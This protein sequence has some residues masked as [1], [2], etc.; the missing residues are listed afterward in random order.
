[1]FEL[2]LFLV[3]TMNHVYAA[4]YSPP[5]QVY[6]HVEYS[7]YSAASGVYV[8]AYYTDNYGISRMVKTKTSD[9]PEELGYYFFNNSFSAAKQGT[10]IILKI[11]DFQKEIIPAKGTKSIL[12]NTIFLGTQNDLTTGVSQYGDFSSSNTQS[13]ISDEK[14]STIIA[15]TLS[16][17]SGNALGGVPI[18]ITWTD[19]SDQKKNL[20]RYTLTKEEASTQGGEEGSYFTFDDE[21]DAKPD[22]TIEIT[23][24][25]NSVTH[26]LISNPGG[27]LKADITQKN[28]NEILTPDK[29]S[30]P[31]TVMIQKNATT[32]KM[33]KYELATIMI[34]LL[35]CI[36][37]IYKDEIFGFFAKI[38]LKILDLKIIKMK[39]HNISEVVSA[40]ELLSISKERSLLD[41]INIIKNN[42]MEVLAVKDNNKIIG[43]IS[44]DDIIKNMDKQKES[45]DKI[46]VK[47]AM[48]S[49]F[50]MTSENKDYFEIMKMMISEKSGYAAIKKEKEIAGIITLMD[51]A[52]KLDEII[53]KKEFDQ[54]TILSVRYLVDDKG[55]IVAY[56]DDKLLDTLKKMDE[57]NIKLVLISKKE[58]EEYAGMITSKEI[59]IEAY[60]HF[61]NLKASK[62]SFMMNRNIPI[63]RPFN[64]IFEINK[65]MIEKNTHILPVFDDKKIL[66]VITQEK[67]LKEIETILKNMKII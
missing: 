15:G 14:T 19:Y 21:I 67:I 18:T 38:N 61:S 29:S 22:S 34:L 54:A 33:N 49:S 58:N 13:Q 65:M 66:G 25:N 52:K 51:L 50:I 63:V 40:V 43:F 44:H 56:E 41:A 3:G 46:S 23:S 48:N 60:N 17:E 10:N 36:I 9:D 30:T 20:T 62:L 37:I 53:S 35:L 27:I 28:M 57:N 5:S 55:F 59:L 2:I 39:K 31:N 1:M 45:L 47:N 7:D 4:D 11:G 42:D 6:G 64:N 32:F 16:D 8:Y 12:V 26:S 24:I